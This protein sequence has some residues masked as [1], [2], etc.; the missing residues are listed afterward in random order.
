MQTRPAKSR[1]GALV[2]LME[3]FDVRAHQHQLMVLS[4]L[5]TALLSPVA[6]SIVEFETDQRHCIGTE[7]SVYFRLIV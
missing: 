2:D 5:A 1:F 7:R 3:L 6:L 4:T